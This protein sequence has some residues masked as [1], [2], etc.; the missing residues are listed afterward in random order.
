MAGKNGGVIFLLYHPDYDQFE[1]HEGRKVFELRILPSPFP[2]IVPNENEKIL[3]IQKG[4]KRERILLSGYFQHLSLP[5]SLKIH[6]SQI[7]KR[8][9]Y[10]NIDIIDRRTGSLKGELFYLMSYASKPILQFSKLAERTKDLKRNKTDII[11]LIPPTDGRYLFTLRTGFFVDLF[12]HN[13]D[14][15]IQE[16]ILQQPLI[17]NSAK[18]FSENYTP[19]TYLYS[20][21]LATEEKSKPKFFLT[22]RFGYFESKIDKTL[23]YTTYPK[24]WR[25]ISN[26]LCW[27]KYKSY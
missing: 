19:T 6:F 21:F 23:I 16:K 18:L 26:V 12:V 25:I 8:D 20:D 10:L 5:P 11:N 4:Q 27:L 22:F 15:D 7:G 13:G 17:D 3:V 24:K 1:I 2:I 9:E 14:S